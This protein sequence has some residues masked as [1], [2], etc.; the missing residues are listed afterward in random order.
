MRPHLNWSWPLRDGFAA[1][2][3]EHF[4]GALCW[5]EGIGESNILLPFAKGVARSAGGFGGTPDETKIF[6]SGLATPAHSKFA[7]LENASHS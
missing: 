3:G 7:P 2:A 5:P 1:E 4:S 6:A